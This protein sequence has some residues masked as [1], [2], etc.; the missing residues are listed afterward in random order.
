MGGLEELNGL[1]NLR[2]HLEILHL[3]RLKFQVPS[4]KCLKNKPYLQ[5]LT[6]RWDQYD[7][8]GR[9][10]EDEESLEVLEPHPTLKVLNVVG[11]KGG[12]FASWLPSLHS[13]VKFSLC[14]C[15]RCEF[16]PPLDKLPSLKI[17]EL[18]RIHSL[19]FIAEKC[20]NEIEVRSIPSSSSITTPT[21]QFFPSL[22]ELTLWDCPKLE[23]WWKMDNNVNRPIFSCISSLG[24]ELVL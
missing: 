11:Y 3:E 22:K 13:L 17:L 19:K 2:G 20:G 24:Q 4:S 6:L 16:L 14:D 23:R 15:A 5:G 21:V 10:R 12:W 8:G 18:W 9:H 7:E 1:H